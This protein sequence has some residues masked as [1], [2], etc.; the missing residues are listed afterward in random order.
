MPTHQPRLRRQD[1]VIDAGL[2]A[3][4]NLGSA[5]M[6]GDAILKSAMRAERM[7]PSTQLDGRRTGSR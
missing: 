4:L 2:T 6:T 1:K 7:Q 3:D 5:T